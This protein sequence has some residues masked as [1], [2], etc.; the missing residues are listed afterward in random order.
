MDWSAVATICLPWLIAGPVA[1]YSP[2]GSFK[3]MPTEMLSPLSVG[4]LKIHDRTPTV[5]SPTLFTT[6][7][8]LGAYNWLRCANRNG[9]LA[10]TLQRGVTWRSMLKSSR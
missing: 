1:L 7:F 8:A 10:D 2:V 5:A 6:Y 3:L 4:G 9:T